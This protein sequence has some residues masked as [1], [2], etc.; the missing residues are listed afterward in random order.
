MTKF[1]QQVVLTLLV[2]ALIAFI[3]NLATRKDE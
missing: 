1:A 2:W 3:I